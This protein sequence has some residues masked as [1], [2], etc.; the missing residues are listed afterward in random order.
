M[1]KKIILSALLSFAFF[2]FVG[3]S[4]SAHPG[5]TDSSGCHTCKTNCEKWGFS[6]GEYHCHGSQTIPTADPTVKPTRIPT[7]VVIQKTTPKTAK[8]PAKKTPTKAKKKPTA[9]PKLTYTCNC[10]KTCS[11]LTCAEAYY[12]LNKCGC[13]QRDGDGDGVPCEAQCR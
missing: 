1:S 9:T 11:Q 3:S 13:S 10:R 2:L 5:R 7:K 8:K 4:T 6:Y 12:Q